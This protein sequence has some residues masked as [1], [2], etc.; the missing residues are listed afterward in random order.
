MSV[1]IEEMLSPVLMLITCATRMMPSAAVSPALPTT[2]GRR[3]YMITPR[4]VST[5][6]VNTPPNV[7]SLPSFALAPFRPGQRQ[8]ACHEIGRARAQNHTTTAGRAR[9][10]CVAVS[11]PPRAEQAA[12]AQRLAALLQRN[13]RAV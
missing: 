4:I 3:R 5:E 6:G 8:Q 10:H 9:Q 2:A 7:P 12:N 13:G 1:A 11:R